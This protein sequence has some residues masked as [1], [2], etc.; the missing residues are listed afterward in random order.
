MIIKQYIHDANMVLS[1]PDLNAGLNRP[2]KL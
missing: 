1:I 2:F